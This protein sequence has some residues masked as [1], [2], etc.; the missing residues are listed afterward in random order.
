M[1]TSGGEVRMSSL[2]DVSDAQWAALA[3][4]RIFFGHQSV[5]GNIIEGITDVIR[6]HPNIRLSIVES[7]EL[8]GTSQPAFQ[9]AAVGRNDYPIEKFDDFVSIASSGFAGDGGVAMVKL[10][11]TDVHRGTDAQ[12][13]FG[14]YQKRIA[15]LRATNPSLTVVH[16]TMPLTVIENW[17]GR[18]M[19][20]LKGHV[21]QRERNVIRNQYNE[22]MRKAYE[23]REPLFDI[24]RLE[25]TLPDGRQVYYQENGANIPMLAPEYTNDGGHL[26]AASRR[27]IAE[28]LLIMLARL[29]APGTPTRTALAK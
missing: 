7:R 19:A 2:S 26:N 24:A 11:Y 4:R 5:G 29:E 10:C 17:K 27:A 3:K 28:Q 12:A 13:L 14:D 1:T 23:G 16:F 21:T 8:K 22:L 9:H 18:L 15:A 20:G 25:S 6:S